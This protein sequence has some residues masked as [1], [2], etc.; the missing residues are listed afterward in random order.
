[1]ITMLFALI[2]YPVK[3]L[4]LLLSLLCSCGLTTCLV[5]ANN[6]ST[7]V[8]PR[9]LFGWGWCPLKIYHEYLMNPN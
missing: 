7:R 9:V 8:V 3:K 5:F 4:D 2:D 1:M 6:K